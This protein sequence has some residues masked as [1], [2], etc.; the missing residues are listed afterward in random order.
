MKNHL[1]LILGILP[2]CLSAQGLLSAH[3]QVHTPRGD[4][5]MLIVFV[6]YEDRSRIAS[7]RAWPDTSGEGVLP[8]MATGPDNA[9]FYSDPARLEQ[10]PRTRNLSD[11]YYAMS[12][13]RFRLTADVFPMQVPVA[14]VPETG[15]NFFDRQNRMNRA[16][17]DWIATHYPGFDWSRYDRRTN[18][19]AFARD[20]SDSP[21][22]SVLDYV[23]FMHRDQGSTG[24]AA[25]GNI[26]IAGTP[27][28]I[29]DGHT[30]IKSY[31]DAK[32]N[33]EYFKHEFCH[34]LFS[35][36]HYL[37]ANSAD[38]NR[39]YTQKGWGLMS[40]W[41]APFFSANAWECWWL[42]W[43]EVQE[44]TTSGQYLLRDLVTGRDALRIALPGTDEYL[45]LE[46]HQKIDPW[47]DKIFYNDP[48][49]GHPAS[50]RGLYLYTVGTQG[51]HRERPRLNPFAVAQANFIRLYNAQGN[52]DYAVRDTQLHESGLRFPVFERVTDNP[53]AGQNDFQFI[54]ADFDGDG[55]MR[56][57]MRHGNSDNKPEEQMDIW[58]E[59]LGDSARYTLN[60][61]GDSLDA[62]QPGGV[63]GLDGRFPLLNYPTYDRDSE[64]LGPFILNGIRI[65]VLERRPNGDLLLDIDLA[66][67]DLRSPRRW[68]GHLLLPADTTALRLLAGA[69][70]LLDRS[71]TPDRHTV[72]G[73]TGLPVNPTRLRVEGK[74]QIEADASL[75]VGATSR[76]EVAS[77]GRVRV[78]RGGSLVLLPGATL[79]IGAGGVVE[80]LPGARLRIEPGADLHLED[81]GGLQVARG[82]RVRDKR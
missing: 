3:G 70:L 19:P 30:G 43:L 72:Q 68:C 62:L 53:I 13:G 31:A 50:A 66:A 34:N 23:V 63:L 82:A 39:Y 27:Y 41:H 73:D 49:Q 56:V 22:D 81:A 21:P 2:L 57:G 8:V 45:W 1:L 7:A 36:P 54:R 40:A 6:R 79:A 33:W 75:R 55:Y 16:A 46:N 48:R 4:L 52:F 77:G 71:G 51:S 76:L 12:G 35:A 44:V 67:W 60:G 9:L 32:H 25:T 29:R 47:D 26:D 69:D 42:G 28:R 10:G 15:G 65:E 58:Y 59:Y 61:T 37:G 5:H 24:M 11:Y 14:Y 74:V 17:I 64:S 38:G 80:L 78:A 20:N 18:H